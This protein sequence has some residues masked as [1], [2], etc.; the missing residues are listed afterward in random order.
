MLHYTPFRYATECQSYQFVNFCKV[1]GDLMM[2]RLMLSNGVSNEDVL[3][4]GGGN[5]QTVTFKPVVKI[6]NLILS[7]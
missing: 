7:I 6:E 5:L 3:E 2:I 4:D 1:S